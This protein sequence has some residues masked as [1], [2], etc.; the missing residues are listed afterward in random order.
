MGKE[1][2]EKL[3][4][5][6]EAFLQKQAERRAFIQNLPT[7]QFTKSIYESLST[8]ELKGLYSRPGFTDYL[9]GVLFAAPKPPVS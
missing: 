8:E 6:R 2:D 4:K 9:N 3:R 7:E 5:D 1:K